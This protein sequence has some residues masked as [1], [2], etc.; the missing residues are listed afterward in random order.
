MT[1]TQKTLATALWRAR[2]NGFVLPKPELA[3]LGDGYAVQAG[4]VAHSGEAQLGWKVGSTSPQAQARLGTDRPGA[5]ALLERFCF[6]SGDTVPVFPQHGP[7]VEVEFAFSL[8]VTLGPRDTPYTLKDL[9]AAIGQCHPALEFV[10]S[11]FEGGL[12]AIGR[13]MITADSGGNVAFV[14]GTGTG[15]WR[16]HDLGGLM[17]SL[18]KNG[19]AAAE[20]P[21]ERAL[22]HPLNVMVW[23]ANHC[24][25][26]GFALNAGD[27][28][29]T[30]TCTG[31][32]PIAPGDHLV[33]DFGPL[34]TVS[35]SVSAAQGPP[36]DQP[37]TNQ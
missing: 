2:I 33:G 7:Y 15:A 37:V 11:R 34:G 21:G 23:L 28:V 22:G 18:T 9:E 17:T 20:G 36:S 16:E 3:A 32:I 4:L 24:R 31:L 6:E 8:A 25:A 10:G 1:E 30:G 19:H 35:A 14:S 29:T 13:A 12:D 27:I 26:R 5:G